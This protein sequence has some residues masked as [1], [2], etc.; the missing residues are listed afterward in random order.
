MRHSARAI[1]FDLDDTLFSHRRFRLSGFA[2]VALAIEPEC[3]IGAR[4]L[5]SRM[6]AASREPETYGDEF[7]AVIAAYSLDVAKEHLIA[8]MRGHQP[9]LRLHE[10]VRRTL[11]SLRTQWRLAIVTNGIP[12]IQQRKVQALGLTDI[13]D[14]VVYASEYGSGKGKPDRAPFNE[15][16]TRLGVEAGRAVFVGDDTNT[17]IY[18]AARCGLLTIQT[19]QWRRSPQRALAAVPDAIVAHIV[20]VPRMAATLLSGKLSSHAA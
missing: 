7:G 19:T 1:L 4:T 16:L 2:A 14:T 18:G 13:V 17:D 5:F 9:R 6:V 10:S 11:G 15:A 20:D 12:E 3:G 8:R